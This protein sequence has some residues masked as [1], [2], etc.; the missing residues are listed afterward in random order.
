ML[1]YFRITGNA[2]GREKQN[3]GGAT[4]LADDVQ[5]HLS[6]SIASAPRN[7]E[8]VLLESESGP[9]LYSLSSL[10]DSIQNPFRFFATNNVGK[11]YA[12]C[13][14]TACMLREDARCLLVEN[15]VKHLEYAKIL[16]HFS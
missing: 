15:L 9:H 13:V 10:N 7:P 5:V 6:L 12:L 8:S 3:N 16:T 1:L 2:G 11:Q 4:H 14:G